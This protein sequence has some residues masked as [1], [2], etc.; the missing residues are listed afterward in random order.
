MEYRVDYTKVGEDT[1]IT[2]PKSPQPLSD[3]AQQ[4]QRILSK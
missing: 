4:V 3:F 1:T 2:A